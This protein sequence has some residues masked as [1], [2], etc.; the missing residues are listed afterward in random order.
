MNFPIHLTEE[1]LQE[2]AEAFL[3]YEDQQS[4]LG[5]RFLKEVEI[6]MKK[7]SKNPTHYSFNNQGCSSQKISFCYHFRKKIQ[8]HR[9]LSH[10]SY[11]ERIKM[12]LQQ[13]PRI[14]RSTPAMRACWPKPSNV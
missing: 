7:V 10:T 14:L 6:T 13:R 2:E 9:S 8:A 1:A 4:G 5:E 12:I 3:F 11:K